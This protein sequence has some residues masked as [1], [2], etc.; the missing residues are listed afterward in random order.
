MTEGGWIKVYCKMIDDPAFFNSTPAQ[1]KVLMAVLFLASWKE[2]K[3]D[4]LG[5]EFTL[6]PGEVFISSIELADRAGAGITRQI[7]RKAIVR[8]E[9]LGFW[10]IKRARRGMLIS[11]V[12]WD[13]YQGI[14]SIENHIEN[15]SGTNAGPNENQSG[16][17]AGP[18]NK[19]ESKKVRIEEGKKG[20][21]PSLLKILNSFET[22]H[23]TPELTAA[24]VEWA[25]M[26]RANGK[27]VS[28]KDLPELLRQLM[29]ISGGDIARAIAIVRQSTGRKW[30][31]FWELKQPAA[32]IQPVRY[33]K[34]PREL[35]KG[36][37]PP[38]PEDFPGDPVAFQE[39]MNGW[40]MLHG[41][42]NKAIKNRFNE[43]NEEEKA[44]ILQ[45]MGGKSYDGGGKYGT[46]NS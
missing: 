20:D 32:S 24:L 2:R 28:D 1:Y 42:E 31:R 18:A 45:S 16:T 34:P 40:A 11:I 12:N 6:H 10:T 33:P 17:N 15:Q 46:E 5:H 39:A 8:F 23:Q 41:E 35:S 26:R 14:Q 29:E 27:P 3:W 19:E 30:N 4:V 36:I 38:R 13:K 21:P 25:D 37:P 9:K 7:V 22:H 44:K 43:P